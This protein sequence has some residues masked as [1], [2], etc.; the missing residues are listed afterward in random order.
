MTIAVRIHLLP[1]AVVERWLLTMWHVALVITPLAAGQNVQTLQALDRGL[2][3]STQVH[4]GMMAVVHLEE[5]C[6][7]RCRRERC[8]ANAALQARQL[9]VRKGISFMR[10]GAV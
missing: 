7:K 4:A 8:K 10:S 5:L 1:T 2:F 9:T 3:L 6:V